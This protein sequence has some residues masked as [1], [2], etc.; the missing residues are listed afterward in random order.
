MTTPDGD[1]I[2]DYIAANRDRY[3]RETITRQLIAAGH[4]RA[5]INAA[6]EGQTTTQTRPIER[7]WN[8][9]LVAY[10]LLAYGVGIVALLWTGYWRSL[11][12]WLVGYVIIGGI[13]A[14]LMTR[15]R[16][17]GWG[18]VAVVLL[19]PLA[20]FSIWYGTCLAALQFFCQSIFA[21]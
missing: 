5:L 13:C 1:T 8:V 15:I 2:R 21:C 6:W 11:P 10:V 4:D 3:T 17:S 14:L 20:F 18:W 12:E 9:R 19:V 7:K 16:V